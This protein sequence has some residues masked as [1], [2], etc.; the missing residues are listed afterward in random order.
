ML[1]LLAAALIGILIGLWLPGIPVS[2]EGYGLLLDVAAS[3][4]VFR[5]TTEETEDGLSCHPVAW[6]G[7]CDQLWELED[8][9]ERDE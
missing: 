6:Q 1:A 9:M 8:W 5:S 7:L 4:L 3:A 2:R